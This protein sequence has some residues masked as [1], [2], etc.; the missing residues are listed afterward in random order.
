LVKRLWQTP[1]VRLDAAARPPE[2]V[3]QVRVLPGALTGFQAMDRHGRRTVEMANRYRH[4][5]EASRVA[6]AAAPENAE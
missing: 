1:V 4:L 3:A 6:A 5:L 2:P